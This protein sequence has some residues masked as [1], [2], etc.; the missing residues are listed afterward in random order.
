LIGLFK[1]CL[2]LPRNFFLLHV[3]NSWQPM[4]EREQQRDREKVNCAPWV[5]GHHYLML[6]LAQQECRSLVW[7]KDADVVNACTHL[8]DHFLHLRAACSEQLIRDLASS[9]DAIPKSSK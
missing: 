5:N 6:H 1:P 7:S 2:V 8:Y 9:V 3:V 4:R